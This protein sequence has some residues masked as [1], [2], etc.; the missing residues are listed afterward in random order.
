[1]D[2]VK[3]LLLPFVTICLCSCSV[4][5]RLD[6][7]LSPGP[8]LKSEHFQESLNELL[9]IDRDIHSLRA[10]SRSAIQ[11]DDQ[12]YKARQV[13]V[14]DLSRPAFRQETLAPNSAFA[15]EVLIADANQAL[16][17]DTTR[18]Q[19]RKF[20]SSK[21][22]FKD[23]IGLELTQTELANLFFAN[24]PHLE[25]CAAQA[26]SCFERAFLSGEQLIFESSS[27]WLRVQFDPIQKVVTAIE[28]LDQG[29][30]RSKLVVRYSDYKDIEGE[31]LP[32]HIRFV[33]QQQNMALDYKFSS[34]RLNSAISSDLF[35][36]S[37]PQDYDEL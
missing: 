34:I 37:I 28:L 18:H 13:V 36:L 6:S 3:Y 10:L 9:T 19:F 32:M 21:R 30:K 8:E 22:F 15:L 31:F 23:L 1:M 5:Q 33:I 27:G 16:F 25:A 17:L 29:S 11:K 7:G 26:N 35:R 4:Y 2:L 24:V 20:E 14:F 12:F